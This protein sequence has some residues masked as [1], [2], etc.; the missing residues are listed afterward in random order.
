MQRALIDQHTSAARRDQVIQRL[1]SS[2]RVSMP[3]K[4]LIRIDYSSSKPER[5]KETL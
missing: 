1:S 5:M 3:S 2:L 4:D